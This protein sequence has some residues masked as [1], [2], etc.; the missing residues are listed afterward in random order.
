MTSLPSWV[1]WA[2]GNSPR[3]LAPPRRDLHT[4]VTSDVRAVV[5]GGGIAGVSAALALA[6]RGASVT[7]IERAHRLGGRLAAWPRRMA[8]GSTH[9]VDHGFHGFFR[10]YY[11]WRNVL[12][13]I[14]PQLAFLRP[15]GRYPVVSRRW[16]EED[17]S[18][19]PGIPPINLLALVARSP[20]LRLRELRGVDGAAALPLLSYSGEATYRTY[21]SMSAAEFLDALGMPDRARAMLFDVFA[22]SFFN[23][24]DQMSAAEMIMQF[25]FY[26]LRNP[27]GLDLD[28]PD[29][30]YETAIWRPLGE[31]L[32]ALGVEI[33]T[34][35][36][37]D[38]LEPGWTAVLTG[39]GRVPADHVVLATDPAAARAIVLAS[40]ELAE[41]SP[42]L[43]SQVSTV[44]TTAPY[45]VSR[46]WLKGDVAAH[47][48]AFTGVSREATLDSVSLYHR[49]E[50]EPARWARQTGGSVLELH[51][52]AAPTGIDA[53]T[54]GDRMRAELAVLW[55]ESAAL[56]IV[57]R[58]DRLGYDAPAFDVDSAGTRPGVVTDA[59]GL[60]LAG[61][62]V[63]LPIPSALMERAATSGL[64]AANAILE[65]HAVAPHAVFSVPPRG[66]LARRG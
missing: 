28:A 43:V 50:R 7:L 40:S 35:T 31:R 52:Y 21:D 23:H 39:G 49:I 4:T 3:R 10:Q 34:G 47:R 57:D 36:A 63:R 17:F 48:T 59:A 29:E 32:G 1:R 56:S 8:D 20:S 65:R 53:V 6:E 15:L 25:H 14:D 38:R 11:N 13:R 62:W 24:E 5:V 42:T 58:D 60:F 33:R 2:T 54:L 46:F 30:D 64:L 66:L 9:M 61:D 37:V 27:E 19:L 44:R 45:C 55:P 41:R 16:P 26:F 12:R 51:A 18:G 22:H